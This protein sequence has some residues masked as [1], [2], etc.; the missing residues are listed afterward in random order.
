MSQSIVRSP[1]DLS[2]YTGVINNVERDGCINTNVIIPFNNGRINAVVYGKIVENVTHSVFIIEFDADCTQQ[3]INY[4]LG[5]LRLGNYEEYGRITVV[6]LAYFN[7]ESRYIHVRNSI[8]ALLTRDNIRVIF[9]SS[10]Y[11]QLTT[12]PYIINN[13]N[14]NIVILNCYH[15]TVRSIL[16]TA[17]FVRI[18]GILHGLLNSGLEVIRNSDL[19]ELFI[20][21]LDGV[22]EHIRLPLLRRLCEEA[23]NVHSHVNALARDELLFRSFEK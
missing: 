14:G 1:R 13:R 22:T 11:L 17:M 6:L 10:Y 5:E 15:V 23:N 7:N 12:S 4:V 21:M 8:H 20:Y 2:L 16:D 3:H 18:N 9:H 19:R